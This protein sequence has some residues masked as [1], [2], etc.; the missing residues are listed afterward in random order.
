MDVT[1]AKGF[2]R[3]YVKA[4]I[5]ISLLGWIPTV[6]V[7]PM[8]HG[9]TFL[10]GAF[11]HASL[12]LGGYCT[13]ELVRLPEKRWVRIAWGVWLVPYVLVIGVVLYLAIPYVPRL[14]AI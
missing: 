2:P 14:F 12:V 4:C 13:L 11:A 5:A 9:G 7:R 3:A 8:M 6:F 1:V 10:E